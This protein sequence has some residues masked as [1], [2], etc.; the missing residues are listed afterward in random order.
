MLELNHDRSGL[1]SNPCSRLE[2]MRRGFDIQVKS[3][4]LVFSKGVK[5]QLLSAVLHQVQ[6]AINS[7]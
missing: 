6:Y 3:V 2:R 5:G 1:S 7:A 4:A